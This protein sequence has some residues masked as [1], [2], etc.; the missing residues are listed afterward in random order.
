VKRPP[1]QLL[2]VT[3]V[4]LALGFSSAT[5]RYIAQSAGTFSGGTACSGQTAIT[6][7]TFNS[8]TLAAGD[9]A[10]IC[11]AITGSAGSNIIVPNNGGTSGNPVVINFDTG[12]SIKAPSCGTY[13]TNPT[14]GCISITSQYITVNGMGVGVIQNTLNGTVGSNLGT[15]ACPGGTC[16]LNNPTAGV[17]VGANNVTVENLNIYDMF[18]R[19]PCNSNTNENNSFGVDIDGSGGSANTNVTVTGNTIHDALNGVPIIGGSNTQSNMVVTNNTLYHMSAGVVIA[20]GGGGGTQSNANI[21]GNEIYDAYYWWDTGDSDHLNGMHLFAATTGTT[22]SGLIVSNNYIHG[23]F[24]G[25]TC[26]GGGSHT[27]AMIYIETTGGGTASGVKVFNNLIVTGLNDD[28]SDGVIGIGDGNDSSPQIYNNTIVANATSG[29]NNSQPFLLTATGITLE[30]NIAVNA[31]YGVYLNG[32][33]TSQISKSNYNDFYPS[34]SFRYGGTIVSFSGWQANGSK[35]D[36]NS[37]ASNPNLTTSY[38]LNSSSPAIGLGANLTSLGI[39]GLNTGAPQTFG[40][41]YA[42]GTGCMARASSGNWA[43]GGYP[44][45]TGSPAPTSLTAVV[46]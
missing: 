17:Y 46:H 13:S 24:G 8:T 30:N 23:D 38:T 44:Y 15:A 12:S 35:F 2:A 6:P 29:P 26:G 34:P 39:A 5:T 4:L 16:K 1:N 42:C 28:P 9:I 32:N 40:A 37:I 43:S 7:A 45:G 33:G 18:D 22:M 36:S 14:G 21:S 25:N 19:I 3:F 20:E 10:W 31:L 11:G 27:T 41:S